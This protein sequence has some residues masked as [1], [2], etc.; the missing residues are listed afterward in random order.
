MFSW[1]QVPEVLLPQENILTVQFHT[2]IIVSYLIS[3]NSNLELLSDR[4]EF[5]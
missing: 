1:M 4:K 3:K 2:G 5:W